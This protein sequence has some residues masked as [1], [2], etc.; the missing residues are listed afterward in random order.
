MLVMKKTDNRTSRRKKFSGGVFSEPIGKKRTLRTN[1]YKE[2]NNSA[3][4]GCFQTPK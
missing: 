2:E 4:F 3:S 1:S